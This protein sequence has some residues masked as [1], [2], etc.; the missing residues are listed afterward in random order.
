MA[1][2]AEHGEVPPGRPPRRQ[3]N[4]RPGGIRQ[5]GGEMLN[6]AYWVMRGRLER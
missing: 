6:L 5:G 1:H 2:Q 4:G 3:G